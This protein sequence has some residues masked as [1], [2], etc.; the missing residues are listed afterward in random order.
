MD[1]MS[2]PPKERSRVRSQTF[3]GIAK[4]MVDQWGN[5]VEKELENK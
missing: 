3:Q 5:F 2:L 4:A 1:T